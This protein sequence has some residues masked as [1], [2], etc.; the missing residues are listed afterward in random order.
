MDTTKTEQ[1]FALVDQ[2]KAS[3]KTQTEFCRDHN[4]KSGT[5]GYWVGKKKRSDQTA[6]GFALVNLTDVPNRQQVEVAYPNGVRVCLSGGNLA[7]IG[8]LIKLY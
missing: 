3:G 5:L 1:M 6:T 2:W 8:R 7:L 4:I